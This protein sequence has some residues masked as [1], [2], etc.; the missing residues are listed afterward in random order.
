MVN[1][2]DI[3]KQLRE[4]EKLGL[5]QNSIESGYEELET[6]ERSP[7]N[8][9]YTTDVL[10][11]EI[12]GDTIT[13]EDIENTCRSLFEMSPDGIIVL[14]LKGIIVSCNPAALKMFGYSKEE[15]IGNHFDKL[16]KNKK[17]DIPKYSEIF[18]S[19][20]KGNAIEPFEL[21]MYHKNGTS[22]WTEIHINLLK[23]NGE[24]IGIQ[25]NIRDITKRKNVEERLKTSKEKYAA[26]VEAVPDIAACIDF[27]GTF[28]FMNQRS[29]GQLG[30]TP[31]DFI[32]KKIWDVFPKEI[33]DRQIEG[34]RR[35]I[36]SKKG[37][38]I[39]AASVIHGDKRWYTTKI[40]PIEDS[41]GKISSVLVIAADITKR[42]IA[43]EK[44][45]E[46]ERKYHALVET[47]SDFV[48]IIDS[49]GKF[50]YIN[51]EFEKITGFSVEE[52]IGHP[53]TELLIPEYV[54]STVNRFKK[55]L[56]GKTIPVYEIE[57]KHKKR[58]KIPVELKVT[59]LLDTNGKT[60]GRTG[61][62]RDISE[63]KHAEKNWQDS[64]DSLDDVIL[65]INKD[66]NIENINKTG[67]KIIGKEK[68]DVI[69][70]KCYQI[71]HHADKAG[72]FC[73]FRKTLQTKKAESIELYE[74]TLDKYLSIKSS[75]IFDEN[76]EIIRFV[77][78]I[79][80]ITE[81][82][83]MEKTLQE[84][85][86]KFRTISSS[87]QDSIIMMD[88]E[89]KVTFWNES[90]ER[91]FGYKNDEIIGKK[92]HDLITPEVLRNAHI[93]GFSK[94]KDTGKGDAIGKMLELSA[95]R[96]DG[97]E[98]PML[99]SVILIRDS[100]G[101]PLHLA[102]SA[103]DIT[104][105]KEKEKEY[106]KLNAAFKQSPYIINIT[107]KKGIIEYVNPK[108]SKITGYSIEESI[109]K[110]VTFLESG[111][112]PSKI[113]EDLWKIISSG[114]EWH[115]EF[116]NKKKNGD[117][118]WEKASISPVFNEQKEVISSL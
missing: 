108:F 56:S 35:A 58:G 110:N 117:T 78:L 24:K 100:N 76:G 25:A 20:V 67:L 1:E 70:K 73:P 118:Y 68:E 88:H 60:I 32:G 109:G 87:A 50:T 64:F 2:P 53:F 62:A 92:L 37:F 46:S 36:S 22:F 103:I 101:N 38:E 112:L 47:L 98:F 107:D 84:S 14:N 44:L 54:E 15:L 65:V 114:K 80:D 49:T 40:E 55:G 13:T 42:K 27:E 30:G 102:A 105:Q 57:I 29:A 51:P 61:V 81:R 19:A 4:A 12:M 82:K 115:G 34:I 113:Y 89:G 17:S 6:I 104:E 96:K 99:M 11:R 63:R 69:G 71:I 31:E 75:P 8:A 59:S 48:F 18:A 23:E 111:D 5:L 86:E 45:K 83:Q 28:L 93:K 21:K 16:G 26:L 106:T 91:M 94:F 74:T 7:E 52:F 116:H 10:P 66:Y 3:V 39:E 72:E 97:T 41:D 9:P 43:E 90:A 79:R 95:L 85:E 33:A 77:E